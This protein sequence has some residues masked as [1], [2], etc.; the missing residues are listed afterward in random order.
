ME[1]GELRFVARMEV[2]AGYDPLDITFEPRDFRNELAKLVKQC[3][4]MSEEELMRDVYV[5]L[6]FDLCPPCKRA[7]LENP[8]GEP[9]D[10][11]GSQD[12]GS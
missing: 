10:S 11:R 2:F 6:E 9:G 7:F 1:D 8:L 3:E 4:G 12:A 5:K